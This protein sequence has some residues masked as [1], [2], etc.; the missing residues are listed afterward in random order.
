MHCH[1][2]IVCH[3]ARVHI[4][5]QMTLDE[6]R[7]EM[8]S[9]RRSADNEAKSLKDPYVTLEKLLALYGKFDDVERRMADQVFIEW[10][11]SEDEELRFDALALIDELKIDRAIPAHYKLA[12]RLGSST[13]PSAPYEVKKIHRIV[14]GLTASGRAN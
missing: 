5:D 8:V 1:R 2:N 7:V 10:A 13:E 3:P 11:L 6:F 12:A 14:A 9:Y 4:G